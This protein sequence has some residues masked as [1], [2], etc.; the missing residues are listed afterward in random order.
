MNDSQALCAR[1]TCEHTRV[2]HSRLSGCLVEQG[3][4]YCSCQEFVE[5]NPNWIVDALS[6][7]E[8]PY[9]G[10]SG[11]SGSDTSRERAEAEDGDGTTH[12]RQQ[13]VGNYLMRRGINGATWKELAEHYGWHHGTASGA[14]SVLHKTG[15][16]ARLAERRY[17]CKVY[18]LPQFVQGR[19]VEP[20]GRKRP[21][22]DPEE[23]RTIESLRRFVA[24]AEQ[25]G[26]VAGTMYLDAARTLLRVVDRLA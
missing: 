5:P 23:Q 6:A 8:T 12:A 25:G 21:A 9:A 22:L 15:H 4:G 17:R 10:T 14:L 24:D 2:H 7:P 13:R 20:H 1:P 3:P 19:E 16:V 26:H 11:W 18:V